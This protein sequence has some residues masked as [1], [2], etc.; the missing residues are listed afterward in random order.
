MLRRLFATLLTLGGT[1]YPAIT[2]AQNLTTGVA[3]DTGIAM[4][5]ELTVQAFAQATQPAP[6]AGSSPPTQ[7]PASSSADTQKPPAPVRV[8]ANQDGFALESGNG[9]FR[10]Q[11]GLLVHS[12][13]RFALHDDNN[14]VVGTFS[15][16]RLRPYL[17]GRF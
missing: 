5:H 14:Q 10:L 12:D 9:D 8:L 1:L 6:A 16:R 7:E 2:L 3:A 15:F 4:A 11:I 17:R 13:G